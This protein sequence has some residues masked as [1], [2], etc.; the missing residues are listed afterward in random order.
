MGFPRQEYW[1]KLPSPPPGDPADPGTEPAD[2]L[3]WQVGLLPPQHAWEAR[4]PCLGPAEALR[5]LLEAAHAP[6]LGTQGSSPPPGLALLPAC[7]LVL[8]RLLALL[9]PRRAPLRVALTRL[10]MRLCPWQL[11]CPCLPRGACICW[12]VCSLCGPASSWWP[13]ACLLHV[14]VPLPGPAHGRPSVKH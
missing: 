1:N 13:R 10:T 5:Q 8:C 11:L 7:S 4:T 3:C 2:L 12:H 9:W 14:H 6:G